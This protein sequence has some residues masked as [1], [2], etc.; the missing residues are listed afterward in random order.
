M[1]APEI[2]VCEDTVT[3]HSDIF[4]KAKQ[5]KVRYCEENYCEAA[6]FNSAGLPAFPFTLN[7]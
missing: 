6:L 3:L 7:L 1:V 5:I 2:D 4:S